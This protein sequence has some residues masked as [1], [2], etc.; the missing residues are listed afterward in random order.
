[1]ESDK[2]FVE[3]VGVY[4][5]YLKRKLKNALAQSA[6]L[7]QEL[8]GSFPRRLFEQ[9]DGISE[10]E[11]NVRFERLK[12][13]QQALANFGL[14]SS[15]QDNQPSYKAE[16]AKA[17]KVY[18]EDTEKKLGVFSDMLAKLEV[19]SSMIARREFSCKRLVIS[20]DDGFKFETDN[21]QPLPLSKLSS[22]EQQELVLLY[23]LLF[24]TEPGAL[25]LIDEPEISLHVA[26]QKAFLADLEEIIRLAKINVVVATHSPQIINNRW[27]LTVDLWDLSK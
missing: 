12:L 7:A 22:G 24:K 11:F 23:E 1:M 17:L 25:L 5:N 18:V 27:D 13:T 26:W 6:Q 20:K 15:H 16:N 9:K 8:D 14:S 4:A 10:A 19:F 2:N 21:G 3:A